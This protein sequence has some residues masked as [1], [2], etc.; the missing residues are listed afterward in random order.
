MWSRAALL[1]GFLLLATSAARA[2][3]PA[4]HYRFDA[5]GH[6]A[7]WTESTQDVTTDYDSRG[8]MLKQTVRSAAGITV[9]DADGRAQPHHP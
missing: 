2:G 1:L 6:L 5:Q 8:H 7:G 9:F 3:A 4:V